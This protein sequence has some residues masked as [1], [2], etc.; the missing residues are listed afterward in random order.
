MN[1]SVSLRCA[2]FRH[3]PSAAENR[4]SHL[5]QHVGQWRSEDGGDH[6]LHFGGCCVGLYHADGAEEAEEGAEAQETQRWVGD[7]IMVYVPCI[8]LHTFFAHTNA[9]KITVKSLRD[10]LS[11]VA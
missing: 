4:R 2:A 1:E 8:A 3:H 5:R 6:H 10:K 11:K 9:R 7:K